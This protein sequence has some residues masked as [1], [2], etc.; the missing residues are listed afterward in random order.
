MLFRSGC[1]LGCL[2]VGIGLHDQR[3]ALNMAEGF[4]CCLDGLELVSE[5]GPAADLLAV[6][7]DLK[8]PLARLGLKDESLV[9]YGAHRHGFQPSTQA[10][11]KSPTV[12]RS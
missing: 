3:Q 4:L 1:I 11:I 12:V 6:T 10:S 9:L 2:F 8:H 7:V 5:P